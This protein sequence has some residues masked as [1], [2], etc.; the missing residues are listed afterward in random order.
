MRRM[1]REIE[2]RALVHI[3][4]SPYFSSVAN[5]DSPHGGK[6]DSGAGKFAGGVQSLE[7]L[8]QTVRHPR[9]EP[10]AII[11]DINNRNVAA[12]EAAKLDLG[13]LAAR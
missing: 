4:L 13:I 3:A 1:K 9:I 7:W 12:L 8:E 5:D 2:R 10:R 11:A 6:P